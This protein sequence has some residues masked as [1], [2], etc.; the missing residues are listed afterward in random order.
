MASNGPPAVTETPLMCYNWLCPYVHR[1]TLAL[2]HKKVS[3]RVTHVA[4]DL[5][6]KPDWLP[7]FSPL[8]KVPAVTYLEDGQQQ[9]LIESLVLLQW[10]QD[11]FAGVG[12]SLVP[13][14]AAQAARM[15]IIISR[16]DSGI[17][18]AWYKLLRAKEEGEVAS[19]LS[20]LSRELDWVEGQMDG[21]GPFLLGPNPTL[22]DA[23]CAPWL[24]RKFVVQHWRGIDM[25]AGRPKLQAWLE[26]YK[27]LP[28]VQA[29]FQP[30]EGKSWE[31]AMKEG[32]AKYAEGVVLDFSKLQAK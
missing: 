27:S 15:R 2:A 18:S 1:L 23:A 17:V 25:L 13:S 10:A 31:E 32:Y 12:P 21:K 16:F 29:T 14:S 11:Y 26:H 22:A 7:R 20:D 4:I 30:P 24:L 5:A 8:G 28:E 19:L 3:H 6:N 9:V